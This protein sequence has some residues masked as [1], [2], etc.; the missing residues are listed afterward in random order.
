[1]SNSLPQASESTTTMP[2][3]AAM[4]PAVRNSGSDFYSM[5]TQL[6]PRSA[7]APRHDR[8]PEPPSSGRA[9]S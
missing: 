5:L 8:A 2:A 7:T 6:T 9:I 3:S 1:M 4:T